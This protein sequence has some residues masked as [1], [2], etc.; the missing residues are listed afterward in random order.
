MKLLVD[1]GLPPDSTGASSRTT[2]LHAVDSHNDD[3]LRFLLRL[4]QIPTPRYRKAYFAVARSLQLASFG[5]LSGRRTT[6]LNT[7]SSNVLIFSFGSMENRPRVAEQNLI[8]CS[9][10]DRFSIVTP[11]PLRLV[12][13]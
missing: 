4:A 13:D 12:P 3:A 5:G 9:A 11:L 7:G 6:A 1:R 8:D 10:V 2:V